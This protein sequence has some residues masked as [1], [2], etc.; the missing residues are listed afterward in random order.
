M[1]DRTVQVG[2]VRFHPRTFDNA[3]IEVVTAAAER[4]PLAVRLAN[5]WC[6][7]LA[8]GDADY[9]DVL[10][11][12]G[13]TLADGT[14]VAA[15]VRSIARWSERVR[16]P[17]LFVAAIDRGR[18]HSLRHFLLGSTEPTLRA[19]RRE[20]ESRF[21]GAVV[22][23]DWAPPFGPVSEEL[24]TEANRRIKNA[25]ATI[26]WVGMGSPKQDH[27]AAALARRSSVVAV[28]VGAGFDF[29][30]GTVREAPVWIQQIGLEWLF[31][32]AAEPRRLWRRYVL[33]NA[34]FLWIL[35]RR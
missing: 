24:L 7:V 19:L 33:G 21:P 27:I 5:A 26:V 31:R 13:L 23:G 29:V 25:E 35:A 32:L 10:N 9:A 2:R 15:R 3:V 1:T 30:A 28:G 4:R 17:S 22:A 34:R 16:G 18:E 20:L 6:V 14:P 11:G 8:D 12:P